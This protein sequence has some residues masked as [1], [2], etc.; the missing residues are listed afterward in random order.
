M[1]KAILKEGLNVI[2]MVKQLK[3]RYT[4][5]SKTYT[6]A[7]LKKFVSFDDVW[8]IF[9]S[10]CV[11]TKSGIPIKIVF[12]HNRNKKSECL[13]LLSTDYNLS[14]TEVVHIYGNRWS[15]ECFFQSI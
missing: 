3:Q 15:I 4:Y 9:D 12:V 6:L 7:Q 10:L 14:D 13:Y 2:G 8:N 5:C 11:T 1:I